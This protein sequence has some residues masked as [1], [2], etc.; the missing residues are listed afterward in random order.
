[1]KH[2]DIDVI[3]KCTAATGSGDAQRGG[4]RINLADGKQGTIMLAGADHHRLTEY[5]RIVLPAPA[6]TG[7][8]TVADKRHRDTCRGC[9]EHH[10]ITG[11]AGLRTERYSR[12]TKCKATEA[13]R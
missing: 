6:V 1:V 9:A 4:A 11:G 7:H 12:L 8:R 10:F 2:A 13:H 3:R 5:R